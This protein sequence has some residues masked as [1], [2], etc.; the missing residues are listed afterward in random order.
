MLVGGSVIGIVIPTYAAA[1]SKRS[2]STI[3]EDD[4][5]GKPRIIHISMLVHLRL[6]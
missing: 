4:F 6:I 1:N 5:Q 2:T 3:F